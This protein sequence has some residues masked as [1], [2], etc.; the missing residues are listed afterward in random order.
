MLTKATTFYKATVHYCLGEERRKGEGFRYNRRF[1]FTVYR[2]S[3]DDVS[4]SQLH[5]NHTNLKR[6]WPCPA[7]FSWKKRP[8]RLTLISEPKKPACIDFERV[9]GGRFSDILCK[10]SLA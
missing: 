2:D 8:S 6:S 10:I 3:P 7:H 9:S 4:L 1:F 5:N